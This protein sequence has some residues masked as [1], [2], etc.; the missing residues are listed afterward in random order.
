MKTEFLK[1]NSV[2]ETDKLRHAGEVLRRGGLCGMPTETVYGLAANALDEAAVRKI[3]AAKGR[4]QDNPLIVHIADLSQWPALVREIPPRAEALA[5]AFWPGPLTIILPKSGRVP[6]AVSCGLATVAVRMPS[7]PIAAAIIRAAGVPLAAPS[8]NLSGKPSPTTAAHV[9]HDMD[10]RIDLIVDGGACSVGVESTVVTLCTERPR[11]LRPGGVTLEML[12]SVL[13]EVDVDKAVLGETD[14]GERPA[15]P[16]MK[17]KHY[18]PDADVRLVRGSVERF[19]AYAAS[20]PLRETLILCFD[21]E[22]SAFPNETMTIGA[23]S[24]AEAHAHCIF[25]ALRDADARGF[26]TVLVH[27]PGERGVD[28]AVLNRLLRAAAFQVIDL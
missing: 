21:G 2:C 7:H 17:Y 27:C 11:L 10:G 23:P 18:S 3:F 13:G 15:S 25:R 28:L 26:R 5:K 4:P 20:F 24:D 14:A 1:I 19:S 8:A 22:E 16:G 6:D 12:Q 9:L